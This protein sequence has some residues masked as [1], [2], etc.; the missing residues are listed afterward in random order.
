MLLL[1]KSG[2]WFNCL[3]LGALFC[4]DFPFE[5]PKSLLDIFTVLGLSLIEKILT[6]LNELVFNCALV[7]ILIKII[8]VLIEHSIYVINKSTKIFL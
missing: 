2:T 5:L 6:V 3:S 7:L 8:E 4:L 1:A